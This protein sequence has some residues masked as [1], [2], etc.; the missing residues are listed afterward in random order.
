MG[1]KRIRAVSR[2][3][4]VLRSLHHKPGQTLAELHVS[5]ELPKAT[6][7][8][9][10]ATL[11]GERVV[12]RAMADGGYRNTLSFQHR[13]AASMKNHRLAEIAMPHM[14]ALR[15]RAIWPSDLAVRHGYGMV[16][17]ETTRPRAGLGLFRDEIGQQINMPHSA[18][19][20]AYLAFCPERE[21]AMLI[22][23]AFKP[24]RKL[25]S[26]TSSERPEAALEKLL[27]AVRTRGYAVRD[28]LFGR[29]DQ[30]DR[31]ADDHLAA[32]AVPIL[33]KAGVLGCINLVWP[34]KFDLERRI[35]G[36][37]LSDL[38]RTAA[39]LAKAMIEEGTA[40]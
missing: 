21:R 8:R 24:A 19:G 7:E 14:E 16:L 33:S 32:I 15:Q 25:P 10:L 12:W 30:N 9:I 4:R 39:A 29:R 11:E 5:V 38:Q 27:S 20:R 40:A 13:S 22:R 17:L 23:H 18:V 31:L 35:V 37:H 1:I 26:M 36:L 2:A 3:V 28:P 6:L 34:K